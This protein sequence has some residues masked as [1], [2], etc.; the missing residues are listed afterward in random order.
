MDTT[1]LNFKT[2]TKLQYKRMRIIVLKTKKK[3]VVGIVIYTNSY[4]IM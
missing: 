3:C 1:T 4:L 2:I